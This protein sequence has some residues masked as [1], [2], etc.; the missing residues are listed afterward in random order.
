MALRSF[1]V[2][3]RRSVEWFDS[4]QVRR[5]VELLYSG[6]VP[7]SMWNMESGR[8]VC[9]VVAPANQFLVISKLVDKMRQREECAGNNSFW[10]GNFVIFIF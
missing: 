8:V 1:P 7:I 2:I 6:P 5:L 3:V 9:D 4:V 10:K